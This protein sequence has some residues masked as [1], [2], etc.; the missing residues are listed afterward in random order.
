MLN[1]LGIFFALFSLLLGGFL[2]Y[3]AT[4]K[5]DPT[6]MSMVIGGAFFFALGLVTISL[7]TR[8]WWEW[9]RHNKN[10]ARPVSD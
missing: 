2:L 8:E 1:K 5:S 4:P 10:I 7:V 3:D 6:Q 9:R